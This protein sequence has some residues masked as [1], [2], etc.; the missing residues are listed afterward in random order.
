MKH[1]DWASKDRSI[2]NVFRD[3]LLKIN[4]FELNYGLWYFFDLSSYQLRAWFVLNINIQLF[5][6]LLPQVLN[7]MW[8][9]FSLI[10]RY[11]RFWSLVC[12]LMFNFF[13]RFFFV[14][15]FFFFLNCTL[16]L[17]PNFLVQLFY[18]L[19]VLSNNIEGQTYI[20]TTVLFQIC[21]IEAPENM[22]RCINNCCNLESFWKNWHASYN[23]WLVRWNL[24]HF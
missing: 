9:K 10:W 1:A 8:L 16:N 5:F 18:Q 6:F 24:V 2:L 4:Q 20:L 21:G 17:A 15:I 14:L 22:P 7:F 12:F 19:Y 23:K 13:I 11:F 3:S